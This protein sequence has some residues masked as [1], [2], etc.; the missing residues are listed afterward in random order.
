VVGDALVLLASTPDVR[1]LPEQQFHPNSA[2]GAA[3]RYA[4]HRT[5]N[6]NFLL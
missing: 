1:V 3:L 5:P 2:L 6:F 4:Q